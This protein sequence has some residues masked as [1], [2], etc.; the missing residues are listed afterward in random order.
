MCEGLNL[1]CVFYQIYIFGCWLALYD[2]NHLGR[3]FYKFLFVIFNKPFLFFLFP[4]I[5][6]NSIENLHRNLHLLIVFELGFLNSA[7]FPPFCKFNYKYSL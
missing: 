7:S 2:S 4:P 3:Y 5:T 6:Q 1:Y